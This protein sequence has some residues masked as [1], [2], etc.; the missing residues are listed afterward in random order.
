MGVGNRPGGC[1]GEVVVAMAAVKCAGDGVLGEDAHP[2][3]FDAERMSN[4]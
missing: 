1:C 3:F 2:V 4:D